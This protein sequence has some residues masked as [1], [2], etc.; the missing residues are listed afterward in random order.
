MVK[1]SCAW[2]IPFE[3][4]VVRYCGSPRVIAHDRDGS[5]FFPVEVPVVLNTDGAGTSPYVGKDGALHPSPT[6]FSLL[7]PLKVELFF[8]LH[9]VSKDFLLQLGFYVAEEG[10]LCRGFGPLLLWWARY[11]DVEWEVR[12]CLIF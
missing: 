1:V 3:E 4:Q 6:W 10:L 5:D 8:H 9:P 2:V 7:A 12:R 11:S